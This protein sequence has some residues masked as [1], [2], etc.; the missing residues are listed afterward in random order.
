MLIDEL[1]I[2]LALA[3]TRGPGDTTVAVNHKVRLRCR[4]TGF[5]TP[6]VVF[7]RNGRTLSYS[8]PGKSVTV[9]KK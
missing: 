3:F 1:D 6:H 2:F 9:D 7:L 5:P 4:V 8:E